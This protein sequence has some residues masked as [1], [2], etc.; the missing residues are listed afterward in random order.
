MMKCTLWMGSVYLAAYQWCTSSKVAPFLSPI[1]GIIHP[2]QE[3]LEVL[4]VLHTLK[5]GIKDF[6]PSCDALQWVKLE[7]FLT[8]EV[9]DLMDEDGQLGRNPCVGTFIKSPGKDGE[10]QA[11]GLQ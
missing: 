3:I 2:S 5:H 10:Y 8:L 11:A 1:I 6:V 9:G 4:G 7:E